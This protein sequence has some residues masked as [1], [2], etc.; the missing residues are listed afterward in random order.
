MSKAVFRDT[1]R[2]CSDWSG[3]YPLET[4][5]DLGRV[6]LPETPDTSEPTYPLRVGWCARCWGLQLQDIVPDDVLFSR[7]DAVCSGDAPSTV[8]YF[9]AYATSIKAHYP[10]EA[11]GFVVEVAGNDG[12]LLRQ[13]R[14]TATELLNVEP[15]TPPANHDGVPTLQQR[16]CLDTALRIVRKHGKADLVLANTILAQVD[17]LG[18]VLAGLT[19]LMH[20]E[21]LAVIEFPYLP[22]LLSS[23]KPDHIRH[24]YRSYFSL[25]AFQKALSY[26]FLKVVDVVTAENLN[27]SLRVFVREDLNGTKYPVS[28]RVSDLLT[29]EEAL[30]LGHRD[31]YHAWAA[32]LR[33]Q[34]RGERF[35]TPIMEVR[36]L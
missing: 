31:T 27:G 22:D 2:V 32:T 36:E 17:D 16:F 28:V 6:P 15:A 25:H 24:E 4:V 11:K 18:D 13:F 35:T 30:G 10:R 33:A 5:L 1:C 19:A 14:S 20:E 34:E 3:M 21:S 8:S 12:T 26:H 29:E 23:N 7:K 9:R